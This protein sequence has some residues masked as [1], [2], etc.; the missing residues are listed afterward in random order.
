M[1]RTVTAAQ[2]KAELAA[3]IRTAERGEAVIITRH[4]KPAAALVT[5][6]AA[7][8]VAA[9]VGAFLDVARVVPRLLQVSAAVA[10]GMLVFVIC[11]RIVRLREVDEVRDALG[12]GLRR[13]R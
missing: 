12:A 10:A 1:A 7:A 8:G 2:A 11:A 6:G 4:G 3:C 9:A 13:R 5:A